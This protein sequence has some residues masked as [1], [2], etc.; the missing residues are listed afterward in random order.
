[1]KI[2]FLTDGLYPFV[3]GGMQ[4]HAYNMLKL[5]ANDGHN[6]HVIHTASEEVD[7]NT[8]AKEIFGEVMDAIQFEFIPTPSVPS[9]PG[10]YIRESYLYGR[11]IRKSVE[12]SINQYNLI[13]AKGFT[14]WNILKRI[15]NR[16]KV[17]VQLHGFEMYQRSFSKREFLEKQILKIPTS[18]II[19]KADYI[20][21][22]GGEIRKILLSKGVAEDKIIEQYGGVHIAS[23]ELSPAKEKN[24]KT[25]LFVARYE[26]RKGHKYLH[27]GIKQILSKGD[28]GLEFNIVGEV[29]KEVQIQSNLVHYHG[30]LSEA[31]INEL[32]QKC[33]FLIIPSLS[34]GFPTI[35]IEMMWKG[36][37]P[38]TTNVGAISAAVNSS[39]GFFIEKGSPKSLVH[40]LEEVI[41]LSDKKVS[42]LSSNAISTVKNKFSWDALYAKLNDFL[43]SIK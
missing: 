18:F 23:N 37:I 26:I 16:P 25:F 1:M 33:T 7:G 21:S 5:M 29:P 9:I 38:I 27:E 32:S 14:A 40:A 2:L 12:K 35:L 3:I 39:N 20:L 8:A 42:E 15:K 24:S 43:R 36:L 31:E 19:S 6:V 41:R 30:N 17:I 13:L 28:E 22:Y 11:A 4:K 34:E 10:H